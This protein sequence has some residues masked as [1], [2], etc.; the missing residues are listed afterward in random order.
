MQILHCN[1]LKPLERTFCNNQRTRHSLSI[2]IAPEH[3]VLTEVAPGIRWLR[4]PLPFS[5]NHINLWVLE[6]DDGWSIVDTGLAHPQ[7][8]RI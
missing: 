8:Q 6:D 4:M 1:K 2:V 7:S 5:L 3:G